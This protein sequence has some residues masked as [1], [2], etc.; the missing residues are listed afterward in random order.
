MRTTI[1]AVVAALAFAG[2]AQ[3]DDINTI[4]LTGTIVGGFDSGPNGT[5]D[6]AGL[7]GGGDLLNAAIS[8][9]VSYDATYMQNNFIYYNDGLGYSQTSI[10]GNIQNPSQISNPFQMSVT[11]GG[12]PFSVTG[13]FYDGIQ[14]CPASDSNCGTNMGGIAAEDFFSNIII[15]NFSN[16]DSAITGYD[17]NTPS[18]VSAAF[19]DPNNT[20]NVFIEN[21]P[22]GPGAYDSLL[23]GPSSG[24]PTPEP[25]T[26]ILLFT[27][28]CAAAAL[29]F[30]RGSV[31]R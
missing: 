31:R 11:I 10:Y 23:F 9:T 29:R 26:W 13:T 12:I 2:V 7:F 1:L 21:G 8:V 3:A 18:E 24:Q 17:V 19:N 5:N 25:S 22:G 27:G 4:A 28:L 6:D 16:S 30:R 20:Y 14:L 15:V